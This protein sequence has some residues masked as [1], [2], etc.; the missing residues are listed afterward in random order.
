MFTTIYLGGVI[1]KKCVLPLFLTVLVVVLSACSASSKSVYQQEE[2]GTVTTVTLAHKKDKLESIETKIVY[3]YAYF[4]V[5]NKEHAEEV[6]KDFI[7]DEEDIKDSEVS[8]RYK[9]HELEIQSI[10]DLSKENP[11]IGIVYPELDSGKGY[12]SF[13]GMETLLTASGFKK[14]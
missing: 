12:Y 10:L 5:D 3:D 11:E 8:I 9:E 6:L 1:M 2:D 4:G 7:P 14:K 13:E